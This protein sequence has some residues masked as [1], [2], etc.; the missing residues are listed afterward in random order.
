M[1]QKSKSVPPS[2]MLELQILFPKVVQKMFLCNNTFFFERLESFLDEFEKIRYLIFDESLLGNLFNGCFSYNDLFK[3]IIVSSL[4]WTKKP[5]LLYLDGMKLKETKDQHS[6]SVEPMQEKYF[7]VIWHSLVFD[8]RNFEKI[9]S[10][11]RMYK[12]CVYH[13]SFSMGNGSMYATFKIENGV[14]FCEAFDNSL[15]EKDEEQDNRYCYLRL[16]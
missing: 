11:F 9:T 3:R 10:G 16:P 15:Y 12:D 2:W 5:L 8:N 13:F 7:F 4:Y 6:L 1:P 14:W